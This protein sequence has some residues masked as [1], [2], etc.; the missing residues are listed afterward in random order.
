MAG[1]RLGVAVGQVPARALPAFLV[2]PASD[3]QCRR[4]I[5]ESFVSYLDRLGPGHFER[6]S[7]GHSEIPA[8]DESPEFYR[9]FGAG[10]D[11]SLADR[12]G[13]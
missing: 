10:R 7:E 3:F 6:L 13:R 12:G 9:D 8:Y 11:F 1:A 4:R 5:G 2:D